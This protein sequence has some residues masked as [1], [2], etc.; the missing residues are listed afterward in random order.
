MESLGWAG[1]DVGVD[2]AVENLRVHYWVE[3][4]GQRE[5]LDHLH[6]RIGIGRD[7]C[8]PPLAVEGSKPG[9]GA[10]AISMAVDSLNHLVRRNNGTRAIGQRLPK[11]DPRR[12]VGP[13]RQF[14]YYLV[15][16]VAIE[17]G[18]LVAVGVQ[19]HLAA[20][21]TGSLDLRRSQ[22]PR[23]EPPTAQ[24]VADP[25]G[26]HEAGLSPR[27]AVQTCHDIADLVPNKD[28]E[29]ASV[30]PSSDGR[31]VLI[32]SIREYRNLRRRRLIFHSQFH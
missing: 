26:L 9:R 11:E 10:R 1:G 17:V 20:A 14:A 25:K 3:V 21:P 28:R 4:E 19:V 24:V 2:R 15:P 30:V 31:V 16:A 13:P 8:W 32:E 7:T 5:V 27:P 18:R 6:G 29:P 23:A 22:Q 12:L